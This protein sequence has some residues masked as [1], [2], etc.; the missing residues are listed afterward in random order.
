MVKLEL[1]YLYERKRITEP[2]DII[3]QKIAQKANCSICQKNWL[4]I[5]NVA[6]NFHFTRGAFDRLII[7][8][9][10]LDNSILITK[11]KK[12]TGIIHNAFGN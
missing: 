11:D 9:A 1:Q 10:M 6:L 2:A 3:I 7:A 12:L 4:D 5:I 8:H